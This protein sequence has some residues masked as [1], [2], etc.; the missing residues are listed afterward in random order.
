[1][2]FPRVAHLLLRSLHSLLSI[3]WFSFKRRNSNA[4]INSMR[5]TIIFLEFSFVREIYLCSTYPLKTKHLWRSCLKT[6]KPLIFYQRTFLK[7]FL[8]SFYLHFSHV[9]WTVF[10][11]IENTRSVLS[12]GVQSNHISRSLQW[13]IDFV[14][15]ATFHD[16]VQLIIARN[17]KESC[18]LFSHWVRIR[19]ICS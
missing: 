7:R 11:L 2:K 3:S 19:Y 1:M 10:H 8:K 13:L 18:L 16:I 4:T 15:F 14:A 5:E 6:K 12:C 9:I 17:I